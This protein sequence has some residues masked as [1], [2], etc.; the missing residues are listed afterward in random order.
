MTNN[1]VIY[2]KK[3]KKVIDYIPYPRDE[4]RD[5]NSLKLLLRKPVVATLDVIFKEAS[6]RS[7][8]KKRY[9]FA[10]RS[11]ATVNSRKFARVDKVA[12]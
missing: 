11:L 12:T 6:T 2:K 4:Q 7:R 8:E 5:C 9:F 10:S 1:L 3:K